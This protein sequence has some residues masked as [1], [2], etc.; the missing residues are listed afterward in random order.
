M[1][2]VLQRCFTVST[3]FSS[4][5]L[6]VGVVGGVVEFVVLCGGSV[7]FVYRGGGTVH[8]RLRVWSVSWLYLAVIHTF[9]IR[10]YLHTVMAEKANKTLSLDR[11]VIKK[12]EQES[13]QSGKVNSLLRQEYGL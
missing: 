13:N 3:V 8:R 5:R 6:V 4:L 11:D 2:E 9:I 12:L 7:W 1:F 10:T